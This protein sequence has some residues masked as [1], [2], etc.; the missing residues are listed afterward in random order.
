M[1]DIPKNAVAVIG[2][3]V[4]GIIAVFICAK[5]FNHLMLESII[6]IIAGLSGYQIKGT[7]DEEKIKRYEAEIAHLQHHIPPDSSEA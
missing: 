6:I 3:V 5:G 4:L 7:L 1:E 2:M